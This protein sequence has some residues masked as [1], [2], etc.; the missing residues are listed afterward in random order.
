MI[1]LAA[2]FGAG[3]AGEAKEEKKR[4]E[5]DAYMTPSALAS[6]VVDRVAAVAKMESIGPRRILEPTC[7]KGD[8]LYALRAKWPE[9]KIVGV[10]IRDEVR[11]DVEAIG[12]RFVHADF[13]NVP[14]DAIASADLIITNP[15]FAIM[16]QIATH[17]LKGARAGT[18]IALLLRLS[19]LAWQQDGGKA[20]FW[21]DP[22]PECGGLTA[23]R[24]IV[25]K[26]PIIPRPSFTG[27]GRT[28]SQEY[29]IVV[30]EKGH[31][32]GGI[33]DP[34]VWEKPKTRRGRKPRGA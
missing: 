31:D 15:P 32:N 21:D 7:G 28:D 6:A 23:R 14:L 2:A 13:L 20:R 34:I 1:D 9:A 3:E 22:I 12:A 29:G 25:T 5:H 16:D 8:F 30:M 24:Q 33:Y 18:P 19:V 26:I 10:D 11:T 4:R 27:D 17:A